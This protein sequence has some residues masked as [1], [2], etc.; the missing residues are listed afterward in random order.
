MTKTGKKLGAGKDSKDPSRRPAG[1]A[2]GLEEGLQETGGH[3]S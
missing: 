2:S 3:P 1:D